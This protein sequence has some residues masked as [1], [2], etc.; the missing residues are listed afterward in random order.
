MFDNVY[1]DAF[2]KVWDDPHQIAHLPDTS[3]YL[4][5]NFRLHI[6]FSCRK[7]SENLAPVTECL[8]TVR[9]FL[10]REGT[11]LSNEQ[12][13]IHYFAL[14][15]VSEPQNHPTFKGLFQVSLTNQISEYFDSIWFFQPSSWDRLRVDLEAYLSDLK[16]SNRFS[17]ELV[18]LVLAHCSAK[19]GASASLSEL[20]ADGANGTRRNELFQQIVLREQDAAKTK[21]RYSQLMAN[22]QQLRKDYQKLI[23]NK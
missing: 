4:K 21:K 12:E 19:Q 9:E 8:Q 20:N 14:P 5:V 23:G 3:S 2:F 10:D 15:F 6:Y 18:R 22:H 13:F 17:S 11:A 16:S 7:I 1:E